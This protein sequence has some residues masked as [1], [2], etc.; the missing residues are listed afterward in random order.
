MIQIDDHFFDP[1]QFLPLRWQILFLRGVTVAAAPGESW[2]GYA[3]LTVVGM[4][5]E[6]GSFTKIKKKYVYI[7]M[8]MFVYDIIRMNCCSL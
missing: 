4:V 8:I 2:Q 7:Y 3:T 6:D 5:Y 1:L